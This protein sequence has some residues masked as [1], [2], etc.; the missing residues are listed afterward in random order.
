MAVGF[1]MG[2]R[3]SGGG[4]T[5]NL[6]GVLPQTWEPSVFTP[7]PALLLLFSFSYVQPPSVPPEHFFKPEHTRVIRASPFLWLEGAGSEDF[8]PQ[9]AFHRPRSAVSPQKEE[10]AGHSIL[11]HQVAR[12]QRRSFA[13]LFNNLKPMTL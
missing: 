9:L 6:R 4:T 3:S 13:F 5:T 2:Q 12:A 7:L 11:I 1:G 8:C 10:F